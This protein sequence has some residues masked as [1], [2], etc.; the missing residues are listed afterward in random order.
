MYIHLI[1]KKKKGGG[2]NY[3]GKYIFPFLIGDA[4]GRLPGA[5]QRVRP[6]QRPGDAEEPQQRK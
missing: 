3:F 4:G 6:A 1:L 5:G 2:Y